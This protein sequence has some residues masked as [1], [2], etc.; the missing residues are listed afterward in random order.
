MI[1]F[2]SEIADLTPEHLQGGFFEGW[3]HPPR[4]EY[5]LRI[6]RGSYRVI[7]A[8][9]G[10]RVVGFITAISDGVSTAFIPL[11]EVLPSYRGRGIGKELVRRMKDALTELYAVDVACDEGLVEFYRKHGFRPGRAMH[12]RNYDRQAREA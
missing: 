8:R 4:P 10:D 12:L 3:P 2:T 7:L 6:L 9:D 1:Q 5:H 11:L